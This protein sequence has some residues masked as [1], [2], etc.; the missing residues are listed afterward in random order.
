MNR[1]FEILIIGG[2]V[3]GCAIAREL[4]RYQIETLLVEKGCDVS[5][6][7]SGRNSGVVHA[8]FYV[9]PGTLKAKTNIRGHRMFPELCQDLNVPFKRI[10]KLVVAKNEDE[11]RYLKN[12]KRDG[13]RNGTKGLEIIEREEIKRLEPGIEGIAALY[14]PNSAIVCPFTLTIGLAENA[15]NNGVKFSLNTEVMEISKDNGYFSVKTSKGKFK[16]NFLVNSAGLFSDKIAAMVGID[17]YRI[18]PCRGE[19]HVL[20]KNKSNL[21]KHLIYSVPPQDL[22]S[23]GIHITPTVHGNIMLG[24]SAEYIENRN[25]L[26]TTKEVMDKLYFEARE[27]LPAIDRKDVIRSFSGIRP[28]LIAP[29]SEKPADFVI[30]ESKEVEG[31]INLM[32]IESPGLTS[33]P[34]IA[35][36]V[37]E[38]INERGKLKVNHNFN[39]KR[40]G[41]VKD[42]GY[43]E[44]VCRC[45]NITRREVISAIK[46]PLGARSINSIKNRCR[47][48]TGRCQG[49]FCAPKIVEIMNEI[50]E[51]SINE[52]T[53]MGEGS[54]LFIGKTKCLRKRKED[55]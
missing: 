27:L 49:G 28:K 20:D 16:S 46:N 30:E 38:M 54:E 10:G 1:D 3:V 8:G 21:I 43:D 53:L 34:A 4:S 15:L 32:G 31:F 36:M 18:Y 55:D 42:P 13:E 45:E 12:L 47:A 19:Y 39:P 35:E 7:I 41:M 33:A 37:V 25:D 52:I 48:G 50:Y 22:I 23:L 24:P 5:M 51:P 44:I 40:K 17:E 29:K 11:V 2:G 6:G 9:K 14:S 26:G